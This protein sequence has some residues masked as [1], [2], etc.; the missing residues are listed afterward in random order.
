MLEQFFFFTARVVEIVG[1]GIIVIGAIHATY[2]VIKKRED[3]TEGIYDDFRKHLGRSILLGLEFLVAADIIATV[4]TKPDMDRV[5][6]LGMVVL[7]RTFLSFSIQ[8][9]LE[10]RFPWRRK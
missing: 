10:G 8:V 4:S 7:I 3:P 9:E 2:V 6:V 1:V 5:L